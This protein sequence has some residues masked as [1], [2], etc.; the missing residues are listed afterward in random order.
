MTL[1]ERIPVIVAPTDTNGNMLAHSALSIGPTQPRTG[2]NTA[3]ADASTLRWA[4]C[5]HLA[6]WP[7]VGWGTQHVWQ[8]RALALLPI[9]SR[10]QGIGS[11]GVWLAGVLF[12]YVWCNSYRVGHAEVQVSLLQWDKVRGSWKIKL[13]A[14]PV[15]IGTVYQLNNLRA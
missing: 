15:G 14:Y 13:N 10:R 4:V 6:L 1:G 3:P 2:V 5:I 12:C 7:A 11:A 8:T 9:L